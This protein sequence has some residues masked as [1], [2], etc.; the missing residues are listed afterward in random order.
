MA[1]KAMVVHSPN[2]SDWLFADVAALQAERGFPEGS[3]D[4][5]SGNKLLIVEYTLP[6]IENWL[7]TKEMKYLSFKGEYKK[8]LITQSELF[9]LFDETVYIIC[10]RSIYVVFINV[11]LFGSYI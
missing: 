11:P 2:R 7:T 3:P 10:L 5:N 1:E 6:S 8:I 9:N 4:Y